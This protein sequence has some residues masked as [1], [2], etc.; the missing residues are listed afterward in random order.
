M[1][2]TWAEGRKYGLKLKRSE[3]RNA[4][5]QTRLVE[6]GIYTNKGFVSKK[7][8]VRANAQRLTRLADE[9]TR[10]LIVCRPQQQR[11]LLLHIRAEVPVQEPQRFQSHHPALSR[12]C[13]LSWLSKNRECRQHSG[14]AR[15]GKEAKL[16]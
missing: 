9:G 3:S 13:H 16:G 15:T 2:N 11:A 5:R 8:D 7:W 4:S 14:S 1:F 6:T 10:R 12:T